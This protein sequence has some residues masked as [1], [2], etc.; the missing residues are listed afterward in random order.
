MTWTILQSSSRVIDLRNLSQV[1][2]D[3]VDTRCSVHYPFGFLVSDLFD[4]LLWWN[5][6]FAVG[7]ARFESLN[8]CCNEGLLHGSGHSSPFRSETNSK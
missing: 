6:G 3:E 4:V 8:S 2:S 1:C 5:F 7:I